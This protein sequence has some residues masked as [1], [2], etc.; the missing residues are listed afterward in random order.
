MFSPILR[1][2]RG[3]FM[4]TSFFSFGP[5]TDFLHVTRKS[6]VISLCY[7]KCNLDS[8]SLLRA[9]RILK[10]RDAINVIKV[11]SAISTVI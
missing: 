9:L 5:S 11:V 2:S 3:A 10:L 4:A 6:F 8:K 7:E 1:S